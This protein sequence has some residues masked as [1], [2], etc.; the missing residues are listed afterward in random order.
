MNNKNNKVFNN[1]FNN[2]HKIKLNNQVMI[3]NLKKFNKLMDCY[4][5]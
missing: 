2:K 5:K 4:K 1:I 3:L